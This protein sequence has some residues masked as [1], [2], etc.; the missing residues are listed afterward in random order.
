MVTDKEAIV[1]IM[2]VVAV[3]GPAMVTDKAG[4]WA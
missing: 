1:V 2:V 4:K 3:A